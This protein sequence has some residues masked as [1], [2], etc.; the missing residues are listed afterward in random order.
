MFTFRN[1]LAQ[2]GAVSPQRCCSPSW[3]V[4]NRGRSQYSCVHIRSMRRLYSSYDVRPCID[5]RRLLR[6]NGVSCRCCTQPKL[7]HH[8]VIP[9]LCKLQ[10]QIEGR[11]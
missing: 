9:D 4:Y 7:S 10:K 2:R 8:Y 3:A 5:I 1:M 11:R 6:P